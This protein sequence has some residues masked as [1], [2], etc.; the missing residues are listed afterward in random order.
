MFDSPAHTIMLTDSGPETTV[1]LRSSDTEARDR[2]WKR[3]VA[4]VNVYATT[5][6]TANKMRHQGTPLP[7]DTN[8]VGGE[9]NGE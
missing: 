7:Q 6:Q 9:D 8:G 5:R 2:P 4:E 1:S 3:S